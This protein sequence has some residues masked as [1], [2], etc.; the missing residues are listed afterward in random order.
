MSMRGFFD[1][2]RLFFKK[3]D[4]VILILAV[5]AAIFGMVLISSATA[6]YGSGSYIKVQ[7]VAA[8]L[9][10]V[11]F[12]LISL[13]DLDAICNL[14]KI[15]YVLNIFLI[16]SLLIFG[17]GGDET[18]NRAWIRFGSVGIQPAEFG[19]LLFILTLS[20]HIYQLREQMHS[21]KAILLMCLHASVPIGMVI[22]I[23]QD[24]GS[25]LVYLFIFIAI[26][27]FAGIKLR[28][29]AGAAAIIGACT[30]FLWKLLNEYQRMRILVVFNPEL[31]PLGKGYHA[32]QS[33]IAL[34]AGGIWGRGLFNGTQT[35]YGYLPAKHTD[36]IFAVAG[37]ELGLIGCLAV[38]ALLCAIIIRCIAIG[39]RSFPSASSLACVGVAAMLIFQTVENIG[40]CVGFM[41]VIG[42]TLPFFSY[43]GSS[44]LSVFIAAGF[45]S[46]AKMRAAPIWATK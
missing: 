9:G 32:I 23:S 16:G 30:P 25:A 18:G 10:L 24:L 43:G 1:G 19:K 21:G 20:G 45:I 28:W 41:P 11:L 7:L 27:F 4:L 15:L 26:M 40:M 37:E 3:I 33:K 42:I 46:S 13:A 17:T 6:S 22:L 8:I 14:W 38:C 12:F 29:F 2:M 36:F 31:D 34:G 39:R 44:I 35:Q 5:C